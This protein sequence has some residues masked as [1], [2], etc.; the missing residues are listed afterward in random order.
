MQYTQMSTELAVTVAKK[1][2]STLHTQAAASLPVVKQSCGA[3][4][5]QHRYQKASA[6]QCN[7]RNMSCKHSLKR[8]EI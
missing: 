8:Q 1:G 5:A 7:Q 2:V 3:A 6:M 4:R